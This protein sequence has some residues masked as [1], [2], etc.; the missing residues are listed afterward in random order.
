MQNTQITIDIKETIKYKPMTIEDFV[1]S[2][3]RL[4]RF[5]RPSIKYPRVYKDILYRHLISPQ[6]SKSQIEA[7]APEKLVKLV[8]TIWNESIK[9]I[10]HV[11]AFHNTSNLLQILDSRYFTSED[12]YTNI[13]MS[14]KLEILNIVDRFADK[15]G[16]VDNIRLLKELSNVYKSGIRTN[17]DVF[18]AAKSLREKEF[19]HYPIEKLV[20][21][22]GITEEILLPCFAKILGYDF[23]KNGIHIIGA[24]GKSK[25]PPLY[26]KLR[27]IVKLPIFILLDS[28][29][30][31]IHS[32]ITKVLKPKDLSTVIK[33]GEFEDIVS[34]NLIKR[35]FNT[36][37]YDI[38]EVSMSDIK[39]QN[40]M[41]ENIS[42]IYRTRGLGEFQKAHF[43]KILADNAKYKTDVS[44]EISTIIEQIKSI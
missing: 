32:E 1:I 42:M 12:D 22:E 26:V 39:N 25:L 11:K 35:A 41:C 33:N 43:A 27:N 13:L 40:K 30:S 28:D 3:D 4:T 21:V 14:A 2:I 37:F 29:A 44:D 9:E 10:E 17:I 20:L 6:L 23:D 24:G 5:K 7:L 16:M 19:L 8:E 31:N 38:E 15:N 36:H 18:S 34:K